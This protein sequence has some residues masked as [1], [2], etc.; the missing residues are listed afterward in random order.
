MLKDE[1]FDHISAN[2]AVAYYCIYKLLLKQEKPERVE[3]AH[4]SGE[5]TAQ[6]EQS[7]LFQAQYEDKER[8]IHEIQEK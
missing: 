8:S 2:I 3:R 5:L 6:K 1:K 7:V 4:A